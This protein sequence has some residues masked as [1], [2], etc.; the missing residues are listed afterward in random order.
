[1]ERFGFQVRDLNL[2]PQALNLRP[3]TARIHGL[4]CP[5]FQ[6]CRSFSPT[7]VRSILGICVVRI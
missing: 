6:N 2:K 3:Q 7:M 4:G 1:M 5:S